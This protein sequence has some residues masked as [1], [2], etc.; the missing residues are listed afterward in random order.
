[1]NSKDCKE[2]LAENCK[3]FK[4]EIKKKW[5]TNPPPPSDK[6]FLD[7]ICKAKNWKR[8]TKKKDKHGN[9]VR[10]FRGCAGNWYNVKGSGYPRILR[11]T[12]VEKDGEV[13][14]IEIRKGW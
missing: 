10:I 6:E 11:G 13:V 12:I 3:E 5:T 8:Y 9:T 14:K 1:M 7:S 4:D 2:I